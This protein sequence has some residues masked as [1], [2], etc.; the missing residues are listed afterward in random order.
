[1]QQVGDTLHR[2]VCHFEQQKVSELCIPCGERPG[3]IRQCLHDSLEQRPPVHVPSNSHCS[4]VSCQGSPD[5]SRSDPNCTLVAQTAMVLSTSDSRRQAEAPPRPTLNHSGF[6]VDLSSGCG[7][8]PLDSVEDI[9][10]IKEVIDKARKPSTICLYQHKWQGFL[11]FTIERGLQPSPVSLS[12]LLLYLRHLFDLG[13]TKSTL[14]AVS[15]T[16]LTLPT[17]A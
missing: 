8:S 1:M 10:S 16:H 2:Y 5:E 17:K 11:Q 9:P 14:K 12:T 6:E 3:V 7:I 13:L 15:Y 4:K